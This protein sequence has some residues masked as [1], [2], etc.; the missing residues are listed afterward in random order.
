MSSPVFKLFGAVALPVALAVQHKMQQDFP[1]GFHG[2]TTSCISSCIFSA[3][4]N[5]TA[6]ATV[7]A[8]A[9]A[10]SYTPPPIKGEGGCVITEVQLPWNMAPSANATGFV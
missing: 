6:S 5:A 1:T 2:E 7:S 4:Q 9:V 3:T 10:F 8:M